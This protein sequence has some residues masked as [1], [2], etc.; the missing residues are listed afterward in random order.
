MLGSILDPAADKTLM[1]TL[2]ITLA[3]AGLLPGKL[4]VLGLSWL[5][6]VY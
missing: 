1:T 3:W 2:V 4:V 5:G 6:A